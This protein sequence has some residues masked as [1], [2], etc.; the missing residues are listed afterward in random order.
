[1]SYAD[2]SCLKLNVSVSQPDYCTIP[3]VVSHVVD[4]YF[5]WS[6]FST[7]SKTTTDVENFMK[8]LYLILRGYSRRLFTERLFYLDVPRRGRTAESYL[9]SQRLMD[10]DDLIKSVLLNYRCSIHRGRR[11]NYQPSNKT[12]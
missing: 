2:F 7:I 11:L 8:Y 1:M 4:F 3:V 9:L 6:F 10:Y 12:M 5:S